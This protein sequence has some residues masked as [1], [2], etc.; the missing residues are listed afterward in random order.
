VSYV[1]WYLDAVAGATGLLR[2]LGKE[3][4]FAGTTGGGPR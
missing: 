3:P 4:E 2:E 1:L